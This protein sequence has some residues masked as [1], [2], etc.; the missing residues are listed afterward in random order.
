MLA[1]QNIKTTDWIGFYGEFIVVTSS[2]VIYVCFIK[3]SESDDP[4]ISGIEMRALQYGMYQQAQPGT[5]LP[6]AFIANSTV[7]YIFWILYNIYLLVSC[8]I[9]KFYW[10]I[11]YLGD[12]FDSFWLSG[13]DYY[14]CPTYSY[15]ASS[16][17]FISTNNTFLQLLSCKARGFQRVPTLIAK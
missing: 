13:A 6:W 10:I 11:V 14:V 2:T 4:F 7:R 9:F 8:H 16:D 15:L 17:E 5:M 1:V 12:K 3:T